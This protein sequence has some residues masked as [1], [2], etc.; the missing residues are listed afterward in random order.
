MRLPESPSAR[1]PAALLIAGSGPTDRNGNSAVAQLGSVQLDTGRHIA[2]QLSAL[3]YA[4]LR[5]DK[6]TSGETGL[7]SYQL[8]DLANLEFEDV[9]LSPARDA[10][11]LL[12][13]QPLVDSGR[14]SVI[15]HSEGALIALALATESRV[16]TGP[17]RLAL[18]EPQY[19]PILNIL[20]SQLEHQLDAASDAEIISI[21]QASAIKGWL[22]ARIDSICTDSINEESAVLPF[23]DADGALAQIQEAIAGIV[24]NPANTRILRSENG[25]DPCQLATRIAKPNSVLVTCGDKDQNTPYPEVASFA[26]SFPSGVATLVTL[27][28]TTHVLRDIGSQDPA[29]VALPD[30]P[31]YPFSERLGEALEAFFP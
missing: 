29:T 26:A 9:A 21:S 7:G 16:G 25:Y 5:F 4:S 31:R 2:D 13:S 11:G 1:V 17:D 15:G 6:I 23:P 12:E 30:F 3:G 24:C 18:L 27:P 10:F 28:N 22:A 19:A 14:V 8:S 20:K